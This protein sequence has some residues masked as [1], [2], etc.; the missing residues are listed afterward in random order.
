MSTARKAG[1]GAA[2]AAG[3]ALAASIAAPQEGYRAYAY[4]DPVGVL[5]YCYGETQGA[6]DAVGRK[7]SEQEC[8]ALLEKRMGH[9]EQG[10]AT[11]VPGYEGLDV[12]VQAAFNDFSYNLGNGTFCHSS[13]GD[14]LRAGKVREACYR[15]TQFDKARIHGVLKPLPGLTKRRALEQMYCLK[16]AH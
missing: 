15:I 9:Y 16:G 1:K 12:Y 13:I 4:R 2:V 8:R 11:C 14:L 5:T 10:N 3:I 6:K 7:F